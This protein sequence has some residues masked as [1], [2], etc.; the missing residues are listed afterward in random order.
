MS[1][2]DG[3]LPHQDDWGKLGQ[4]I[5]RNTHLTELKFGMLMGT[6]FNPQTRQLDDDSWGGGGGNECCEPGL[7]QFKDF[8]IGLANNTSVKKVDFRDGRPPMILG[9]G[10]PGSATDGY[11]LAYILMSDWFENNVIEEM[12]MPFCNCEDGNYDNSGENR[13]LATVLENF[14]SLKV[15]SI[16]FGDGYDGDEDCE[17]SG[18]IIDA[19]SNHPDLEDVRL[20]HNYTKW[21]QRGYA[22]LVRF[23]SGSNV[24]KLNLEGFEETMDDEGA[25]AVAAALG[26]NNTLKECILD[27]EN[28]TSTGWK[29]FA[30]LLSDS[31]SIM[32]TYNSNHTLQKLLPGDSSY[33]D[34][35]KNELHLLLKVNALCNKSDAARVKTIMRHLSGD[36]SMEPFAE[37]DLAALP[38]A[39]AWM[40]R[41]NAAIASIYP[42]AD[43]DLGLMYKFVRGV[44]PV[45]F[46]PSPVTGKR[47]AQQS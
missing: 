38:T 8:C 46:D 35:E 43:A 37:M 28:I 30:K 20:S 11:G 36:F 34:E 25:I 44:A 31:G 14:S 22:A 41:T 13:K 24:K 23:I 26:V 47:K 40:G 19:L 17:V 9:E 5:G 29:A 15:F 32:T 18:D 7:K 16:E 33:R 4:F 39:L 10:R 12:K 42:H 27:E 45:I 21:S 3:F 2:T 1:Q 6:M